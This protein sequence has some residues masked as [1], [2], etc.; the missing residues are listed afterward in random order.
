MRVESESKMSFITDRL[1][2]ALGN[3]HIEK[4]K[5]K[6]VLLN[7]KGECDISPSLH[8][9]ANAVTVNQ[10]ILLNSQAAKENVG[11]KRGIDYPKQGGRGGG[12]GGGGGN[13]L[14]KTIVS[15]LFTR[16]YSVLSLPVS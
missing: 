6:K 5:K 7:A 14:R 4:K 12:G 1:S 13:Y 3:L 2:N 15:K 10:Q 9:T 16:K 8:T 11:K